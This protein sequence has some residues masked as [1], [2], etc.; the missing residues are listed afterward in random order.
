MAPGTHSGGVDITSAYGD[1]GAA[2]ETEITGVVYDSRKVVPGCLFVCIAGT[3]F[4]SH[5]VAA[6]CAAHGAAVILAQ[7]RVADLPQGVCQLITPDTRQALAY[8]AAAWFGHPVRRMV[9]I[10]VTGTKGKTTTT[11]ML[12]AILEAAGIKV[13]L[14]GT[15]GIYIGERF[16]PT[17][18]TT[19]ESWRLH[20]LFAQMAAE[21]C[22]CVVMEVSSQ[23][24]MMRRTEGITFDYGVF[25]NI[26]SDHI[27][28][29]EHKDFEEYLH[30]KSMLFRSCK[31]G[32]LNADDPRAGEISKKATCR[33]VTF[34]VEGE[35][36]AAPHE[37]AGFAAMD[38]LKRYSGITG[39]SGG[40]AADFAA[41]GLEY[42]WNEDF[43]GTRICVARRGDT[44]ESWRLSVGIPGRFN[45]SNALAAIA[46]ASLMDS[47]GRA[48]APDAASGPGAASEPGAASGPGAASKPGAAG[49]PGAASEPGAAS[50][51]SVTAQSGA[52][53]G[54]GAANGPGASGG[55]GA[56]RVPRA[57][58]ELGLRSVKVN[59]RME[60]VYASSSLTVLVDYA[61]NA[62]SLESLLGTLRGYQPK[63]LV[64]VFGCGGNRAKE[65]RTSMGEIGGRMADLC[66]ITADN[67]RFERVE[68]ILADIRRSIEKTGGAFLEIP[69]RREAIRHCIL[70]AQHG[71]MVVIAG[72]GHEDYQEIKGVKHPF[73]DQAVARECL[74]EAGLI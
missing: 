25:T 7:R 67:S 66:V 29:N 10:G 53:G 22:G 65:R 43:V 71:D 20:E 39:A 35:G 24:I 34:S 61:H 36:G 2:L 15:T 41:S 59:G 70:H 19:P 28:P 56:M 49:G 42:V 1:K 64:C 57:A 69:D 8:L 5:E 27:G 38:G 33:V 21:G 54:P 16:L 48:G 12:K 51:L 30:Y 60:I 58:L 18:N 52:T 44:Q 63:R 32:V 17:G 46:V 6:E 74:G 55:P 3:G 50:G 47:S 73:S 68:D 40:Y 62:V 11:F 72:K 4:D 26:S 13:G 9:S 37:A 23:G 14:I 31:V 45:V